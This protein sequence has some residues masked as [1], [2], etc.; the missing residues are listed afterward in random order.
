[1]KKNQRLQLW[2]DSWGG[3]GTQWPP[4]YAAFVALFHAGDYYEAHDI[5]EHRWLSCAD[6]SRSFFQALIQL[7]GAFVHFQKHR[8]F[9]DHPTHGRRLAP[10]ARLLDL[11]VARLVPYGSA[12]MNLDLLEL[13]SRCA[14]WSGIA[15]ERCNPLEVGPPP[16]L[17]ERD[18]PFPDLPPEAL[19]AIRGGGEA[20]P[21]TAFSPIQ[22]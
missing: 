4:E 6:G 12:H 2:L 9:P 21:Q 7:A 5:L 16:R 14:R 17:P 15:L 8:L 20:G 19:A 13:Q 3:T 18:F 10:G 11:A 1:M 22:S